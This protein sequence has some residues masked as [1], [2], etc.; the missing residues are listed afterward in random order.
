[1]CS[2]AL[3]AGLKPVIKMAIA[4]VVDKH[5][6]WGEIVQE[7]LRVESNSAHQAALNVV[8]EA[9]VKVTNSGFNSQGKIKKRRKGQQT[10]AKT[11]GD[12]TLF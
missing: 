7:V 9:T 12:R 2:S 6:H 4:G 11:Q 5:F 1:M 8:D 3:M 10:Y